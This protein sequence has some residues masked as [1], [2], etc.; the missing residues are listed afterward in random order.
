M[1]S[2]LQLDEKA[3]DTVSY[4]RDLYLPEAQLLPKI[5]DVR[6]LN[7]EEFCGLGRSCC[8]SMTADQKLSNNEAE[9]DDDHRK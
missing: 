8:Q 5:I 2:Q 9:E 3:G 6:K 4:F 7:F 1:E